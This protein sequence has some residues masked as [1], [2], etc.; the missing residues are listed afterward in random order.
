MQMHRAHAQG[1]PF[2]KNSNQHNHNQNHTHK[3]N[4]KAMFEVYVF[5][6][7]VQAPPEK[8]WKLQPWVYLP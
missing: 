4:G 5:E 2:C 3:N 7:L 1:P 6:D 8:D